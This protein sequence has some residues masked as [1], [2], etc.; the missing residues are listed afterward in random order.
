MKWPRLKVNSRRHNE[1]P[2]SATRTRFLFC[3]DLQVGIQP[4]QERNQA[5]N[6]KAFKFVVRKR[7]DFR[8][9][10]RPKRPAASVW[11]NRFDATISF[12]A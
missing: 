8:L 9:V 10:L 12:M 5:L 6:G 11:L 2:T 1:D 4:C 3:R 7:G